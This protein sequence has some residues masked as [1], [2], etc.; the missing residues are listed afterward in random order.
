MNVVRLAHWLSER[1]RSVI[2]FVRPS[3]PLQKEA[4]KRDL[5]YRTLKPGGR[6]G[7]LLTTWRMSRYLRDDQIGVLT[8]HANRDLFFSAAA[9]SLP[10]C[11]T[12]LVMVQH[13]QLGRDKKDIAHSWAY[14]RLTAWV[15]PLAIL[16]DQVAERTRL[17]PKKIRIIPHGIETD[18]FVSG[19]PDRDAAR[20]SFGLPESAYVIGVVGR[21][22]P[23]KGQDVL[24]KAVDRIEVPE[25]PLHILLVGD[26][27]ADEH[28]EYARSL[29]RLA[30]TLSGRVGVTIRAFVPDIERVYACLDVFALTSHSETYGM[31]TIEA[32]ASG[33]PVIATESGGTPGIVADGVNGLLVPPCDS[34]A[35]A[36]ALRR[37]IAGPDLA[38]QLAVRART[39]AVGHYSHLRQCDQYERLFRQLTDDD[40]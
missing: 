10:G 6:Y 40:D 23:Q 18:R 20:R 36:V 5:P 2:L 21:L 32:M 7:G 31:V 9:V 19:L 26:R 14:R 28:T 15:S 17:D 35:L 3:S 13:M 22:D 37:L 24:L 33:V 38:S 39:D 8:V 30:E 25:R 16:G 27:T 1:G 12:P 34:E 11:R 4:R 29:E